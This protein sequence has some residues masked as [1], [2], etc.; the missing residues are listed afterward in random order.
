MKRLVCALA[1]LALAVPGPALAKTAHLEKVEVCGES[2]CN[3]LA[4]EN[5]TNFPT[6]GEPVN[7]LPHPA[8]YY[9]VRFV[10][11]AQNSWTSWYVPSAKLMAGLD[12][13]TG[14]QWMAMDDSR[15]AAATKGVTPFPKPEITGVTVG[16]RNVTDDPES[17]LSLFTVES[18]GSA[19]PQ[20]LADWEPIV[21]QG[22]KSPWTVAETGLFYSASN[23]MLMRGIE[24]LKLPGGMSADIRSGNSVSGASAF[25]WR[26]VLLALLAAA[27]LIAAAG[28]I[29][30]LRRRVLVRRAPTTA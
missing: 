12:G 4:G 29:R 21:F 5:L 27:A 8:P 18:S 11:D 19:V 28:T 2:E 24:I 10:A 13:Q 9:E 7:A 14:V 1:L 26:N 22:S 25:P 30:P 20:G 23:G 3:T 15:M 17:Y 6:G 16:S